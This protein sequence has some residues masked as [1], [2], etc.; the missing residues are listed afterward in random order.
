MD[1]AIV[2]YDTTLRDGAQA[3]GI[4]F[5]CA[6]KIR[7]AQKLDH[8]GMSYIEGG[9]PG[10]NHKDIEFFE[11]IR[12]VEIKRARIAA[13][14]STRRMGANVEDDPQVR[15][16][17]DAETP[18]VTIYGKTSLLHVREVLRTSP[19][20]N[21]AMIH[22][23]VAFLKA[24][25]REVVYDAEHCFDG[26]RESRDY[27]LA[28]L[29]AAAEAGADW[30]ALCDTNGGSLP[31]LIVE[32]TQ[33]AMERFT[34][35]VA[36]HSHDDS[37]LGVANALAAVAQGAS[38]VQGTLNGFG[39]RTGNCNLTSVIP[40][41][42]LKMGCPVVH[43]EQLAQLRDLSL[44]IDEV[45]NQ[46]PNIRAPFI[47]QASFA[48]KG[49][50]H[51]NA[52]NK[53]IHSYEHIDP[54]LVGNCRRVLVGE[55]SGRTNVMLKAR[56]LGFEI[57]EKSDMSRAILDRVKALESDGYEFE[58]A[59][60]SFELLLLR[61]VGQ[62]RR[63]FELIEYHVSIRHNAP[64]Q[65][66]SCEATVKIA[67][68]GDKMYTVADGDGPVN[69]LDSA[70]RLALSNFYPE[71]RNTRLTDYKVR[72]VNSTAG[73]AAK[74]RVLVESTNGHDSWLTV[75]VS[76]NIVEATWIALTD[77][78]DYQFLLEKRRGV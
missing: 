54:T 16:L 8:F 9:W 30:L 47:G 69:A 70:L 45:A 26:Y 25:G 67:V 21:L 62:F 71:I 11:R 3:E 49:G 68:A 51:V 65:Y 6:D 33:E 64:S 12:D 50:T 2:L 58:S 53:L 32:V 17:L 77:A 34:V 60:A 13:F 22:D 78:L 15:L 75:G 66:D 28:C 76:T 59:D 29:A 20:E 27:A 23:T 43:P 63:A 61:E 57:E 10:S 55:L 38:Q 31:D 19:E 42:Q 4:N 7:I 14:G 5:S 44:F 18:V 56:E 46:H 72:I 74:I 39:E 40:N 35:P 48:H 1:T 73:S 37:G 41:L 24:N 36:I 52:I